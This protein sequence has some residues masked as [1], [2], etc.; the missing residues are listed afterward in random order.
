MIKK[1]VLI[2]MD[3]SEMSQ[4]I[5]TH[6]GYLS[7]EADCAVSLSKALEY[8]IKKPYC[9][10]IVDLQMSHIGNEEMIRIFR[11]AKRTPILALTDILGSH[12][13]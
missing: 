4:S 3:D 6:L 13:K 7:T 10:L 2:V 1:Q 9:L 11:V 12:E 5:K 8:V